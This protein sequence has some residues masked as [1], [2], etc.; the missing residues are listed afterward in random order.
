MCTYGGTNKSSKNTSPNSNSSPSQTACVQSCV[1][2]CARSI[3]A[4]H[5]ALIRLA[6]QNANFHAWPPRPIPLESRKTLFLP[7][8]ETV[9]ACPIHGASCAKCSVSSQ[10]S[11]TKTAGMLQTSTP[12][13]KTAQACCLRVRQAMSPFL[14]AS[15]R[16]QWPYRDRARSSTSPRC[17]IQLA[18]AQIWATAGPRPHLHSVEATQTCATTPSRMRAY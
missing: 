17:S 16:A 12:A 2:L 5:L 18:T 13:I 8:C 9:H 15:T 10:N 4:T 14:A 7:A 1:G 11:R 6:F 3:L